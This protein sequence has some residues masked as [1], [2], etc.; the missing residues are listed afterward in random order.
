MVKRE[1]IMDNDNIF[2]ECENNMPMKPVY[3]LPNGK[4]LGAKDF[5]RYF[6]KK[7]LYTI[8]K[9][10]MSRE[11]EVKKTP[12]L[13][14]RVLLHLYGKFGFLKN[15]SKIIALDDSTDDVA[16]LMM[17]SW[18]QHKSVDLAPRTSKVIRPLFL[19]TDNEIKIYAS[20]KRIGGKDKR[21]SDARAMLDEMEKKHPEIKRAIVQSCLQLLAIRKR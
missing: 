11:A 15:S 21:K 8:R 12:Y 3:V 20:L 14:S 4:A 9:F 16:T 5:C 13:N 6:E 2:N 17:E 18:F 10:G 1:Q 19:M 7:I